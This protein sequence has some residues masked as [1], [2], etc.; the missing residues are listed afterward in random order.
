MN[1]TF[2]IFLV[3]FFSSCGI[4]LINENSYRNL[5]DNQKDFIRPFS[6][7]A[8][9][10]YSV[11]K[12]QQFVYEINTNNIKRIITK[13]KFTWLHLWRPY[14]SADYCQNIKFFSNL[15]GKFKKY[16]LQL[17]LISEDYNK[18]YIEKC[19]KDNGF[20]KSVFVLQDSYYGHKITKNRKRFFNEL[21]NNKLP[22]SRYSYEDYLF[23]DTILIYAGMHI[24]YKK[25]D[26]LILANN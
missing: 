12:P 9:Y 11:L 1:K 14:C 26:S 17:L 21:N 5:K 13:Q 8:V 23:K 6:E 16:N 22:S 19:V 24:N 18:H 7:D 4:I 20:K 3:V 15:E 25:M 2:I 10:I